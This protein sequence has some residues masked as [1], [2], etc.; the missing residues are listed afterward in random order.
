MG[1]SL[2][3]VLAI[4]SNPMK[5]KCWHGYVHDVFAIWP[6][7]QAALK[8]FLGHLNSRHPN[9]TFSIELERNRQLPFVDVMV[10]RC[11]DN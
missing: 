1:S 2:S 4:D 7:R 5:L 8:D 10:N 9:I 3:S 11:L 6:H